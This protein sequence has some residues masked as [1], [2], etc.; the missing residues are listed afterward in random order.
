MHAGDP[1]TKRHSL[2]PL[3][4]AAPVPRLRGDL[5][6]TAD[7]SS[8]DN[9]I[10]IEDPSTGKKHA[11]KDAELSLA[12]M[13]NGKRNVAQVIEAAQKIGVPVSLDGL[14]HFVAKMRT[15]ALL[16]EVQ[17]PAPRPPAPG[18]APAAAATSLEAALGAAT[19]A[20]APAAASVPAAAPWAPLPDKTIPSTPGPLSPE[21]G[22][23]PRTQAPA[24]PLSESRTTWPGR[25][26]WPEDVRDLFQAALRAYRTEAFDQAQAALD[27]VLAKRPEMAEA[28]ELLA[29][30]K[31]RAAAWAGGAEPKTF[32]QAWTEIEQ[33]WFAAGER[34]DF[35]LP[36][37]TGAWTA[38]APRPAAP[39]AK[40]PL[41]AGGALAALLV[42]ALVT[43]FPYSVQAAA[44]LRARA[45]A[46]VNAPH[47]GVLAAV[48]VREGQWVE[49]GTVL[50]RFDVE[51]AKAALA[52]AQKQ[53]KDKEARLKVA[54]A[55]NPKR[56]K[57]KAAMEKQDA[58]LAKAKAAL[59]KAAAAAGA[60]KTPALAKA[61]KK[62][63][64]AEKAAL[65]ARRAFV[66]AGGGDDAEQ[67]KL[68]ADA[69]RERVESLQADLAAPEV[70]APAAG[71]VAGV[72]AKPGVA[73]AKDAPLLRLEDT[74]VLVMAV[75]VPE[76]QRAA[77]A[78]GAQLS[79]EVAGRRLP[80]K[81]TKVDAQGVEAELDNAKGTARP[82][83]TGTATVPLGTRSVLGRL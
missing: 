80:A 44:S 61:T 76:K 37:P 69:A 63:A 66:A 74:R 32:S 18:P 30:V 11:L 53:L 43:P 77:V 10:F 39:R 19:A 79:V 65:A 25:D 67:L 13:L 62:H 51:Q 60:K 49:P 12:R 27:A 28:K 36:P 82:G 78:S 71:E 16:D 17:P 47:P 35:A 21:P 8:D 22:T 55:P 5:K 73:L 23:E 9:A 50:A 41:I 14:T 83:G 59:D 40:A 56:A 70:K 1:S 64:A 31:Q 26:E 29:K 57:A 75:E 54:R 33:G 45:T 6:V 72:A 48:E 7:L 38:A 58:A 15:L 4:L 46:P 20:P 3:D 68:E 24:R 2:P 81:V 34:G 52:E 42:G